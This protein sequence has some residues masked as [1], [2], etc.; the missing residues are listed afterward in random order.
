MRKYYQDP[1]F[2][3][4]A[5]APSYSKTSSLKLRSD[6]PPDRYGVAVVEDQLLRRLHN[7]SGAPPDR[8][9]VSLYRSF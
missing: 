3:R 1:A 2:G 4:D 7:R 9:N 5:L 8:Y 6:D